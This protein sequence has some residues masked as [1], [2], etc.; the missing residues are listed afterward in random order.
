MATLVAFAACASGQHAERPKELRPLF[1]GEVQ[2]R[3]EGGAELVGGLCCL[4]IIG[5]VVYLAV[6][7]G[8]SD[9]ANARDAEIER[10]QA[11]PPARYGTLVQNPNC[12]RIP[13]QL[14]APVDRKFT[15][16]HGMRVKDAGSGG[17]GA[18]QVQ[19]G[20]GSIGIVSEACYL[21]DGA[22]R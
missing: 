6:R 2:A 11:A 22:S 3:N 1:A 7:L 20:D 4:S 12:P 10:A 19:F 9:A 15:G 21:P 13:V 8:S 16:S 14:V 5:G 18:R 17:P